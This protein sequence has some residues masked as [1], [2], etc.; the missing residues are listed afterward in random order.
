MSR[1]GETW[2]EGLSELDED[3]P[4]DEGVEVDVE[5]GMEVVKMCRG[6]GGSLEAVAQVLEASFTPEILKAKYGTLTRCSTNVADM[7]ILPGSIS[8]KHSS[9]RRR[10]RTTTFVRWCSPSSRH[11]T[12]TPPETTRAR[13]FR[14][15]SSSPPD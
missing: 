13:C 5:R 12:S 4:E 1:L 2:R 8:N 7:C 6:M 11:T 10:H 9:W 15:A 3:W 14:R